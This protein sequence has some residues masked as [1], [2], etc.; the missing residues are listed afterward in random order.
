MPGAQ[1]LQRLQT[2]PSALI[3]KRGQA[4]VSADRQGGT[5]GCPSGIPGEEQAKALVE[6]LQKLDA[7][8]L[9]RGLEASGLAAAVPPG[10][11]RTRRGDPKAADQRGAREERTLSNSVQEALLR[12]SIE[13]LDE[14]LVLLQGQLSATGEGREGV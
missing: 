3:A 12:E 11:R 1:P 14:R 13:H 6:S 2:T 9:R 4:R 7:G 10:G 5:R 8:I